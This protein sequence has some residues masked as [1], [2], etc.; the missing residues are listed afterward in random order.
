VAWLAIGAL[1]GVVALALSVIQR[2]VEVRA[3]VGLRLSV[4][5]IATPWLLRSA[6]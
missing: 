1:L 3:L 6:R 2:R 5:G 4:A